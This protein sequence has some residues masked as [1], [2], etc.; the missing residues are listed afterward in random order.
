MRPMRWAPGISW[1]DVR[2]AGRMLVRHPAL[3]LV[4]GLALAI[5]IPLALA[6]MQLA[7]ALNVRLPYPDPDRI[8]G[9]EHLVRPSMHDRTPTLHDFERWRDETRSFAVVAAARIRRENVVSDGGPLEVR[10]GTEMTASAF[11][12]PRVPPQ[13]GRTLL[14]SDE[15]AGAAPVV[16]IGHDLWQSQFGGA[17]DVLNRTLRVGRT[18]RAVVGVMPAG[19]QF[20]YRDDFWIPLQA[21][22]R[23][24]PVGRAPAVVVFGRLRKDLQRS[25]AQAELETVDRRMAADHPAIYADLAP[26]VTELAYVVTGLEASGERMYPA[27]VMSVLLLGVVCANVGTLMLARTAGR[28]NEI[29]VRAALGAGRG[30]IVMQLFTESLVLSALSAGLGLAVAELAMQRLSIV[31]R[32]EAAMP[33]WF[34]LNVTAGTVVTAAALAVFSAVIAGLLPALRATGRRSYGTLQ[35]SGPAG[36]LRFGAISSVL[37]VAEVAMAVA[38]LSGVG[39][40]ARGAFRAPALGDEIAAGQFLTTQLRMPPAALQPD[41][42]QLSSADFGT[43]FVALQTEITR[44]LEAEPPIRAVTFA[45][46]LPGMQHARMYV[47]IDTEVAA[48]AHPQGHLVRYAFVAP[49]FFRALDQQVLAGRDFDRR[50]LAPGARPVI[51]NR[52]FVEQM[53]QGQSP[54][55]YR[56]RARVNGDQPA[57][58]W[59]EIIGV[60]ADLGMNILD[61]SQSAGIY[62]VV[63][64]GQVH[65]VQLVVKVAGDPA[66]YVPRLRSVVHDVEPT[67]ALDGPTTLDGLFSEALWQARFTAFAFTLVALVAVVLSA[68]GLYALMAFAVSQRTR[69]IAIRAALGAR[70][71]SIIRLIAAT[72]M[73]QLAIGVV[74]GAGIGAMLVP[75]LLNSATLAGNWRSMLVG[76]SIAMVTIGVLAC[77]VPTR[78]ALRIQPIAA[79]K[80]L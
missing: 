19:F 46:H 63:A 75:T 32:F 49:T 69:E 79:L 74:I 31:Q 1:I 55:G 9:L 5:G 21:R 56:I 4:A 68:A 27:Y 71:G 12:V 18:V 67:M 58:A 50:D 10:T 78:R 20:P 66:S 59:R 37:I 7:N 51:V 44:R 28:A 2:L 13:L 30:R 42:V 38:G 25:Q 14:A 64:P 48:A 52:S 77:A 39:S 34:D 61:P 73:L 70:P 60:V 40:V 11:E 6:P 33:P 76:V 17:A 41:G 45:S 43:R 3:T 35:R 47:E 36:G 65:P 57:A 80:E 8:V 23:D 54:I 26:R 62:H 29:A 72:A 53:F 24:Y 16:V 15:I 22:A